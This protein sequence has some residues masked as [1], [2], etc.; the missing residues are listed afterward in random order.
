[1]PCLE[2]QDARI[3]FPVAR[4][5]LARF[6][7]RLHPEG[8]DVAELDTMACLESGVKMNPTRWVSSTTMP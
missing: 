1:M 6:E 3:T 8:S 5:S 2:V 7:P 4:P